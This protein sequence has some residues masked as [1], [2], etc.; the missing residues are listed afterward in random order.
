MKTSCV[1]GE[2]ELELLVSAVLAGLLASVAF[3]A[4]K[5]FI[6]GL[7]VYPHNTFLFTPLDRFNDFINIYKASRKLA[8]FSSAVSV[9]PPF[10][11]VVMLPFTLVGKK[12]ALSAMLAAFTLFV[13]RYMREAAG[14]AAPGF[15]RLKLVGLAFLSYP[16]LFV[17]DRA[18]IEAM[19]FVFLALFLRYYQ[20]NERRYS[21]FFLACAIAM[22][23]Y[24]AAFL[25]V[26]LRDRKFKEF[27]YALLTAGGLT[28]LAMAVFKGGAEASYHGF[29]ANLA[30]FRADYFFTESGLQHNASL[31]GVMRLAYGRFL[32]GAPVPEL[33]YSAAAGAFA[34][35]TFYYVVFLRAELWRVV[36]LIVCYIIVFPQISFDYKLIHLLLPLTLFLRRQERR[37]SDMLY[38]GLF[39]LMLVPKDYALIRGDISI[40]VLLNPAI[41]LA[42]AGLLVAEGFRSGAAAGGRA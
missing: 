40:A 1:P 3:H 37:A 31:F 14:E 11:Y 30:R 4:A 33:L 2:R 25:L 27:L 41:L 35:L 16:F 7:N 29:I 20:R 6:F 21:V 24:P 9:Y 23:I 39:A 34:L 26:F 19:V 8:P 32:P 13:Y 12:I 28:L 17:F 18:N 42:M 15:G 10:A 38:L 5:A 22:K 36:A